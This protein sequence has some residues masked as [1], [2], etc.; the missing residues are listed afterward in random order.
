MIEKNVIKLSEF[1]AETE[2]TLAQGFSCEFCE[3][4]KNTVFTEHLRTTASAERKAII[5]YVV[6]SLDFL[7]LMVSVKFFLQ[8]I[9]YKQQDVFCCF[10]EIFSSNNRFSFVF[11]SSTIAEICLAKKNGMFLIQVRWW[12]Y[13]KGTY[14]FELVALLR[15]SDQIFVAVLLIIISKN[16]KLVV[17]PSRVNCKS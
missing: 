5:S 16:S 9:L 6:L 7:P 17:L 15:I 14:F 4:F 12:F 13:V 3:I 11:L 8:Y 2:T 10:P 1:R